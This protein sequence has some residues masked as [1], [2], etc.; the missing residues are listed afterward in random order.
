LASTLGDSLIIHLSA[1]GRLAISISAIVLVWN[2]E[3]FGATGSDAKA[4]YGYNYGAVCVFAELVEGYNL[5]RLDQDSL[6]D[7]RHFTRVS[8]S[9][10]GGVT[11]EIYTYFGD[12]ITG[13][14]VKRNGYAHFRTAHIDSTKVPYAMRSKTSVLAL[15]EVERKE[16][17]GD[18]LSLGCETHTV[19]F[20]FS[21]DILKYIEF[22]TGDVD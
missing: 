6:F 8:V 12:R 11:S 21:D 19:T 9:H 15:L 18:V 13:Q 1:L 10:E 22:E 3:G 14:I 4:D 5:P 17:T 7:T 2:S 16:T 20:G